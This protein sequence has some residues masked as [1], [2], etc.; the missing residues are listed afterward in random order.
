VTYGA[1]LGKFGAIPVNDSG[2]NAADGAK[3]GAAERFFREERM[4]SITSSLENVPQA[5]SVALVGK[6]E[7]PSCSSLLM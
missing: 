3:R 1:V 5:W 4:E 6:I 2:K 7:T